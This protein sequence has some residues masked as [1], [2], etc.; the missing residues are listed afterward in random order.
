[1][2][3]IKSSLFIWLVTTLYLVLN[4]NIGSSVISLI[5]VGLMGLLYLT[6]ENKYKFIVYIT[7]LAL[8]LYESKFAFYI[9]LFVYDLIEE[10]IYSNIFKVLIS[11]V[12]I[13]YFIKFKDM[14]FTQIVLFFSIILKLKDIEN[15][16][17][18][19]KYRDF[20]IDSK[21]RHLTLKSENERLIESQDKG[22]KLAISDERNRIAR[23]IHDGVGHVISRTILQTGA[24]IVVEKDEA[25]K[26]GLNN[27]KT[28]LNESMTQLRKSL[29]NLQEDT[30]NLKSELEKIISNYSFSEILFNYS[31]KESNDLN[32]NYSIIYIINECLNN[33]IKHSN[34]TFVE[35]NLR[36]TYDNI[37]IL[38]KDNGTKKSE[39]KYGIGLNSIETRVK[40]INGKV[41][42]SNENGFRV[43]INIEKEDIWK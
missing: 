43:F 19:K 5:S 36:E 20:I 42:I 4:F 25:K 14:V 18:K 38:I 21:E 2:R 23:D 35:I 1:M 22:I 31:M 26:E 41:Q 10:D 15:C 39:I 27:I 37:F 40:T 16:N 6:K 30:I 7:F 3:N 24:M 17:L 32:F 11:V 34:A 8:I 13:I 29:H 9:P 33:V 12:S 28:S